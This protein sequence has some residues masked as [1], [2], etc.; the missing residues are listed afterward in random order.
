MRWVF[1]LREFSLSLSLLLAPPFP[2]YPSPLCS[3]F[4]SHYLGLRDFSIS[5]WEANLI[6]PLYRCR[7]KDRLS[8]DTCPRLPS[9]MRRRNYPRGCGFELMCIY[10]YISD[11]VDEMLLVEML[12]PLIASASAR[13][14]PTRLRRVGANSLQPVSRFIFL[15][16]Y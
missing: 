13:S 2:I 14:N 5:S 15:T 8:A 11:R 3:H 1:T 16:S 4:C 10:I 12:L 6:S 9:A 7:A